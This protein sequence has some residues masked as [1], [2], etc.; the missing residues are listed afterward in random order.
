MP[1]NSPFSAISCHMTSNMVYM[2]V[3]PSLLDVEICEDSK[4]VPIYPLATT[5]AELIL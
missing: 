3:Q 1:K 4:N 2:F 5:S